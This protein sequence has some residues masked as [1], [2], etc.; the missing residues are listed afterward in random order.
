MR[1]HVLQNEDKEFIGSMKSWFEDKGYV[2]NTTHVYAG[3]P[4]PGVDEFDWLI[5]M[6]GSMSVYE[7]DRYPWIEKTK[8]LIKDTISLEKRVLGICLGGQLIASASGAKVY[9]NSAKEIGWFPIMKTDEIAAW[10]PDD[11][12]LLC[13]HGDCFEFPVGATPFAH[14]E[15][16]PCQGF[17]LNPKVWALQFHLEVDEETP[18]I[19]LGASGGDIGTGPYIQSYA[20]ISEAHLNINRSRDIMHALLEQIDS[21]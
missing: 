7:T 9:A 13:W 12:E 21:A 20:E 11:S 18:E 10:L 3:D 5:I 16:T 1:V 17:T 19:F 4:L 8:Q 15:I 14:T 6:G 2:V